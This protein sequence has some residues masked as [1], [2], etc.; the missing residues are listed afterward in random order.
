VEIATVDP[1]ADRTELYSAAM[2]NIA[3]HPGHILA[4]VRF[5]PT[6]EGGRSQPT[7]PKPNRLGLPFHIDNDLFDCILWLDEIGSISPGD[8]VVVPISFVFSQSILVPRLRKGTKFKLC[9]GKD[10]A[11]GE[12]IEILGDQA[13]K[14]MKG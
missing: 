11:N 8:E 12:V 5:L 10:V 7:P 6:A 14:R 13:E 9:E 3:H 4:R 1:S 2:S